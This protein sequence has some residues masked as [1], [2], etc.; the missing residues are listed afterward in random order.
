MSILEKLKDMVAAL[1]KEEPKAAEN[2]ELPEKGH[3]PEKIENPTTEEEQ[4]EPVQEDEVIQDTPAYLEC[5][6]EE[7]LLI[8]SLLKEEELLK[9]GIANL[10]LQF[11]QT[12]ESAL[13]QIR[14]NRQHLLGEL[15]NLRLEYGIPEEG[16][17]V[18]LPTSQSDKVSF[19]KD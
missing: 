15:N 14:E 17:S 4:V 7:T 1:E 10:V 8:L 2:Q 12:K 16:Y 6:Q 19:I 9:L 3:P 5:S 18:K 11:E 13:S